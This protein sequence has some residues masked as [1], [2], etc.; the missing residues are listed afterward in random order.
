LPTVRVTT[1]WKNSTGQAFSPLLRPE[2]DEVPESLDTIGDGTDE[3][4]EDNPDGDA[5]GGE[6]P[7][8]AV[9]GG[10]ELSSLDDPELGDERRLDRLRELGEDWRV[11]LG[12]LLWE[13]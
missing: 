5:E 13:R 1:S 7:D 12:R 3:A 4:F 8:E 6:L 9:D 2:V 10:L 11:S